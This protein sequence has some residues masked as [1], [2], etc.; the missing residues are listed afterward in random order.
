M[1]KQGLDDIDVSSQGSELEAH[2]M[3]R[4]PRK[5]YGQTMPVG[6]SES[7]TTLKETSRVWQARGKFSCKIC[8]GWGH[9]EN[10]CATKKLL[11][12][13]AKQLGREE[14]NMWGELKFLLYY[15]AWTET[16]RLPT[17]PKSFNLMRK[18]GSN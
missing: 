6:F 5:H 14:K 18:A 11:D 15:K 12:R 7:L 17:K 16:P 3:L 4:D 1:A 9:I 10:N 8:N 2:E 13:Y